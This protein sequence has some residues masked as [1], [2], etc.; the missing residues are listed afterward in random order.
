VLAVAA[1]GSCYLPA[2]R[3]TA[4]EPMAALRED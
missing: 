3:A 4:I 1:L 2:R